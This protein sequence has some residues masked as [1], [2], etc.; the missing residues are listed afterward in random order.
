LLVIGLALALWLPRLGA[1]KAVALCLVL[2][3][4]VVAVTQFLYLAHGLVLPMAALL[5]LITDCP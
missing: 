4:G 3:L 2:M 5:A 1:T